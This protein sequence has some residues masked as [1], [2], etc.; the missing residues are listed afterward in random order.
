MPRDNEKQRIFTRRA[1]LLGG[2]Q[3]AG[4]SL[5][6][7]RLVY[8]QLMKD[9]KYVSLSENNRVKLQLVAPE[10][11]NILDWRGEALATNEKNYQLFM[12]MSGLKRDAFSEVIARLQALLPLPDK[13]RER[14]ET[15][16][17][18]SAMRPEMLKENLSWEEVARVELHTAELPGVF[19][20]LGQVRHYVLEEEAAHLTGYV[21]TVSE[22][23]LSADNQPLLRLPDFKIGKNG[24]EEMLEARLRG[25]A[26]VKRLEVDVHGIPVREIDKRESI[27]GE[28]VKLTVDKR[29][30]SFTADRIKDESAAVV[31]MEVDTG[32]ILAM[33]SMPAFNPD[34]F[35]LG[36]KNDYWRELNA[37]KRVP[38]MNKAITGQYPP[39]STFKMLVGLAALE[40][41]VITPATTVTCPGHFD[42]GNH[43][44]NCWKEEGHGVVNY[45]RAVT[46]SCDTFFYTVANRMGIQAFADIARN[47]GLGAT[48]NLGMIG[49]KPGII[50]DP[51]WKMKR[52]KQPWTGGD[53]INCAIGQGYVL[54]TP[55]QLC[56]MTARLVNGGFAVVPKLEASPQQ[57]DPIPVKEDHLHL[58]MEGMS[59]VVNAPNGTAYGKRIIDP[60]F[61]FGG[62]TG[63][64]QVR[65]IVVRGQ[66]QNT[67]PWEQR[68]H[69]LFVG[70]APVDKPKYAVAVTVE[71]GGG[72]SAA[73]A[74]IARDVLQK[75]QELFAV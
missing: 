6:A 66:D 5:L 39:G 14:L 47:F 28:S 42:L 55:L 48:F 13:T 20:N 1:V 37:N 43:R 54:A 17:L 27:P 30:Q 23:E 10:R 50:P 12:D 61:A 46:E 74:P 52:Y 31:V 75:V 63:T 60:K 21:G 73:A 32:H 4:F 72:G 69:A 33:A 11:G 18:K 56:V 71:H 59:D 38:L 41:G 24:V 40:A 64:S 25:T 16:K 26:G 45:K 44:F 3:A 57:F 9:D 7:G 36:I 68:H 22:D 15:I 65:K 62:K 8:L 35:S 58:A 67:I 49:E 19:I 34:I 2:L 51:E 70:Y 29:L 53:T